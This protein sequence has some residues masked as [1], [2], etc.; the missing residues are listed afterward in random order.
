M[1]QFGTLRTDIYITSGYSSRGLE[2]SMDYSGRS[3]VRL[4]GDLN[5]YSEVIINRDNQPL[6]RLARGNQGQAGI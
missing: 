4:V 5:Q 2:N 1:N 6:I 3:G